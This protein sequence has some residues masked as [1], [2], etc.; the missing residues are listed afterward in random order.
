M[1]EKQ[2][3]V[4]AIDSTITYIDRQFG[5]GSLMRLGDKALEQVSVIP[6]GSLALDVAVGVGGI[7]RGRVTEIFGP[8]ASGKT[9]LALKFLAQAQA[10]GG[11]V[12]YVDQAVYFDP[13]YAHR[14][15]LDLSH[16]LVGTTQDLQEALAMTEA[17]VRS[18]SLAALVFESMDCFWTDHQ[19][20]S[21]LAATL[22]R[23]PIPLSR[24]GTILLVL[25]DSASGNSPAL[26]A[27]AHCAT[28]RLQVAREHWLYR[29]RDVRGY[30]TRV[31]VLKNRLGPSGRAATITVGLNDAVR[32]NCL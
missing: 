2:Q 8:E 26:S 30:N 5:K 19:A 11:Q 23:L 24:S 21:H 15:G 12:G 32:G 3:K 1:T 14:C 31:E 25:H 6:T 28:V 4:Q 18:G 29:H 27:L 16:L 20:A 22:N 17:L 9:T 13:D 7:P 10:G